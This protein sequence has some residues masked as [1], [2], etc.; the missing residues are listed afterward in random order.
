MIQEQL[1]DN[2]IFIEEDKTK[3]LVANV[4]S[5]TVDTKSITSLIIKNHKIYVKVSS[6][7]KPIPI[8]ILFKAY[9]VESEQEIFQL[10]GTEEHLL[11][12]LALCL[13]DIETSL[14]YT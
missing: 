11:N 6:F 5:N 13:E 1:A 9:G 4:K 14:V 10:I 7:S 2:R 3:E 8:L 12:R